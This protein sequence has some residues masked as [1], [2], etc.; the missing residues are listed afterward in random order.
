M[1]SRINEQF[2][3]CESDAHQGDHHRHA[4]NGTIKE[5]FKLDIPSRIA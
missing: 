2:K 3:L 5:D 1:A 4:E